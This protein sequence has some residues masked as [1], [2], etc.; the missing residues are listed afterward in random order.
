MIIAVLLQ[1]LNKLKMPMLKKWVWV[2]AI[3]GIAIA[4]VIG[5]I[6][7][8]IFYVLGNQ[9]FSG[10]AASIFKGCICWVACLLI[11]MVAF[12]MLKFYN[13]ERK[14]RRK[15]EAATGQ[16]LATIAAEEASQEAAEGLPK[17]TSSGLSDDTC[18]P[19]L[20]SPSEDDME[21]VAQP[22]KKWWQLRRTQEAAPEK[23]RKL[24][25]EERAVEEAKAVTAHQQRWPLFAVA[26]TATLREGIEAVLFLTGV[27]AGSGVASI[28]IP[29]IVGIILGAICGVILYYSGK[30]IK[31]LKWFFIA[32]CG[33]LLLIAAGLTVTGTGYFTSANLFGTL[34]P[35]EHR[36]WYLDIVWYSCNYGNDATNQGW[37]LLKALF[38]YTCSPTN[39]QLMYYCIFWGCVIAIFAY[40]AYRG[41][42]T[43]KHKAELDDF[44]SFVERRQGVG[45]EGVLAGEAIEGGAP[46]T[47]QPVWR[48]VLAAPG[49]MLGKKSADEGTYNAAPAAEAV[50]ERAPLAEQPAEVQQAN[51]RGYAADERD[52]V[53]V[54]VDGLSAGGATVIY[55]VG[56]IAE[57]VT[58]PHGQGHAVQLDPPA[59][60]KPSGTQQP[61]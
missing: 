36:P 25:A 19:S 26:I 60:T 43:D 8:V 53:D 28:I 27:S 21:K 22:P 13:M 35:Y 45:E 5:V 47:K 44:K 10:N 52:V 33:L 11:T 57:A 34:W 12:H 23:E 56:Q 24:T 18:K 46:P 40:R 55:G 16:R 50:G 7:I 29:G 59:S 3:S 49:R 1:I 4:I 9:V 41:I 54:V 15:L 2:G 6:F 48:K 31:S 61:A 30:T 58:N 38:G 32:S 42:L 14:W 37:A 51:R 20:S 17:A 39:L